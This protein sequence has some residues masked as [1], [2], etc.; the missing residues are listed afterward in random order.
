MVADGA[1]K[2][3]V[4]SVLVTPNHFATFNHQLMLD[5]FQ[6]LTKREKTT[7]MAFTGTKACD[8]GSKIEEL[9]VVVQRVLIQLPQT[10]AKTPPARSVKTPAITSLEATDKLLICTSC[11]I[12]VHKCKLVCVSECVE[13]IA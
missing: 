7:Q 8:K 6:K 12:C 10:A 3:C 13:H 2:C 11:G 5:K 1:S 9:R 4:C